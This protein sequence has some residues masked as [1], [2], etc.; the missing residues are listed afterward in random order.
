[1]EH[2]LLVKLL[3]NPFN[4]GPDELDA[5]QA[6]A[7]QYPYCQP[8]I[9]LHA[10]GKLENNSPGFEKNVEKARAIA[11]DR[12][13]FEKF[14]SGK[15]KPLDLHHQDV[16]KSIVENQEMSSNECIE[17]GGAYP[18]TEKKTRELLID[19]FIE[20]EPR[21]SPPKTN[22]PA[23]NLAERNSTKHEGLVTETLADIYLDQGL[24]GQAIEIYRKLSL[25]NP[26]KSSY[27]AKKIETAKNYQK[28]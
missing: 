16:G 28:T 26:E 17:D 3:H 2:T 1:M 7:Q 14:I 13:F 25:N 4:I 19:K 9:Y 11:I 24:P 10:R 20:E 6:S 5:I 8:L 18:G 27:F 12:K 15:H 23:E 21:I 22:L